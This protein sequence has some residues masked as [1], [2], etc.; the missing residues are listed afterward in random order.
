MRLSRLAL[1]TFFSALSSLAVGQASGDL[2]NDAQRELVL[3]VVYDWADTLT[4]DDIER[5]KEVTIDGSMIQRLRQQP[6]GSFTLTPSIVSFNDMSSSDSVMVER[7]WDEEVV[8]R[9]QFALFVAAYD[10]W[11]DGKFSHCGTD[12][13]DL[14][15]VDGQWKIGNMKF[16]IIRDGCPPSPLGA[17]G[18]H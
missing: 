14:I 1:F 15:Q 18:S 4:T 9:D 3:S 16:T 17:L 12:V 6:D 2:E 11:I 8:I 10:F 13:F 7:F 5:R